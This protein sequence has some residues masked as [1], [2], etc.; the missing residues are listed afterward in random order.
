MNG[1]RRLRVVDPGATAGINPA[2]RCPAPGPWPP[3]PGPRSRGFTLV[4][5]LVVI[6]IIG[7]LASLITVAALEVKKMAKNAVMKMEVVQMD[8]ALNAFKE[9]FGAYPPDSPGNNNANVMQFLAVAFPRYSGTWPPSGV[10]F[11]LSPSN[12]LPFWL[13][14]AVGASGQPNG[15]S[16]NP[17]NPFDSNPSR[18]GPFFSFDTSRMY[19][20]SYFVGAGYF[21]NN[22][23]GSGTTTNSPYVYFCSQ[24]GSYSQ[25]SSCNTFCSN[26]QT[27]ATIWPYTLSPS[28][29]NY[30]NPNTFQI[31]C[32]GLDGQFGTYN[33]YPPPPGNT[34]KN[35]LD[36]I[37]NFIK[38][39]TMQSDMQH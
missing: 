13:G 37:T 34:P 6:T 17:T 9:K 24:S 21:P 11:T 23:L 30:V 3:A 14:G 10:S 25:S 22:G 2:A 27:Q 12:A 36:D 31:L 32:C 29:T 8:Q 26:L 15:F 28:G 35:E 18:I 20:G 1:N 7:V 16:S 19:G 4:E 33:Q 39:A 38:G 5:L